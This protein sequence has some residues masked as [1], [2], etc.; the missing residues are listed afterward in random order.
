MPFLDATPKSATANAYLTVARM[1]EIVGAR[2]YSTL[3]D[4][5]GA[6][7]DAEDYQTSTSAAKGANAVAIDTGTG[8]FAVDTLIKFD[9]HDTI[10]KVDTELTGDGSL[11]F[12][13]A[14]TAA[15]ADNEA[16][17]RK[18]GSERER[19]IIWG[20]SLFDQLLVYEGFKRTIEQ[21][22]RHPR[23]AIYDPDGEQY[24]PDKIA[25]LLEFALAE[26]VLVL[27]EKD[28]FRLPGILGQ[29]LSEAELGPMKVKV[30]ADQQE[31]IIPDNVLAILSPL[32]K[33]E[34]QA[35][36]GTMIVPLRRV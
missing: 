36:K 11:S 34:A 16:V 33:L 9:G 8:T 1:S 24:D 21:A 29:G 20:T 19:T 15:V 7:P 12:T 10:Y 3:W 22:L 26:F 31:A 28:K 23:S 30:D 18:S 14:L 27:L 35:S 6:T 2:P 25:D 13:P 4:N 32:A 5:A 17:I